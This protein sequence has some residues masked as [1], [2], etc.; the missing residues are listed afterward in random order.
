MQNINHS[1]L[2]L[3]HHLQCREKYRD[4]ENGL[5]FALVYFLYH[6]TKLIKKKKALNY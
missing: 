4:T 3:F 6:C 1:M 5:I 2:S